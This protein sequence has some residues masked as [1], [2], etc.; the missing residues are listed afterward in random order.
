M[1]ITWYGHSCFKLDFGKSVMLVDPFLTGNETFEKSGLRV[2]QAI[3][4]VTNI[5]LSHGHDDHVGDT[6]AIAQRTGV[7]VVAPYELA[8]WLNGQG[9]EHV[10]PA[11]PGG[12][13]SHNGVKVT[14]VQA[15]HSSSTMK[16]GVPIYLGAPCGLIFQ[17]LGNPVIYHMGDTAIFADMD[18]IGELYQPEVGIVPIGDRFT[19]GAKTAALACKWYFKFKTIIP[20]HWGT[21]P[22]IDQTPD[23]FIAEMKGSNV[24]VPHVG[25]AFEV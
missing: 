5:V 23:A 9:V 11:N 8:N 4:G 17:S 21:F 3:E 24:V 22:I 16:D 2:D 6:I 1:K 10:D 7:T 14:F 18:L 12:A 15:H 19:M 25:R 13:V 20:C